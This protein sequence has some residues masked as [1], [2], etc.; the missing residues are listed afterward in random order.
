MLKE[1]GAE[2]IRMRSMWCESDQDSR[3]VSLHLAGTGLASRTEAN[4]QF[5]DPILHSLFEFTDENYFWQVFNL[6]QYLLYSYLL[7]ILQLQQLV[8]F[9]IYPFCPTGFWDG[10]VSMHPYLYAHYSITF[11]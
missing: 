1:E 2:E 5:F 11:T 8:A 6:I 3:R 10:E 9:L 4:A 7:F